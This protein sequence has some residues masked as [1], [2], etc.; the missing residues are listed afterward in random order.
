MNEKV[1]LVPVERE[2]LE[3]M[4]LTN[5]EKILYSYIV[6][7]SQNEK[8]CCFMG[9]TKLSELVGITKRHLRRCIA[10]LKKFNYISCT[11]I[12]NKRYITPTINEFLESRSKANKVEKIELFDYD[13][14]NDEEI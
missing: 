11:V 3:N 7:L 13:W 2:V 1:R 8:G 4:E 5:T 9:S 6:L 14:L 10:R 12:K